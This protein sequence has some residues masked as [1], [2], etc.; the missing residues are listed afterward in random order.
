MFLCKV[1]VR[2]VLQP[3]VHK[4][5]VTAHH[6]LLLVVSTTVYSNNTICVHV[7]CM[8]TSKCGH[9]AMCK[10][11]GGECYHGPAVTKT[12]CL[13]YLVGKFTKCIFR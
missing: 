1:L 2:T 12:W 8:V 10:Q 11:P 7:N 5:A 13:K 4:L 6:T 9:I 3:A